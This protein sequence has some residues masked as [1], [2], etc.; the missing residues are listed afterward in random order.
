ML[1][2]PLKSLIAP[3]DTSTSPASKFVVSS[4]VVNVRYNFSSAVVE[5]DETVEL[6]AFLAVI[7]IVG[8]EASR[9]VM[10][11]RD[12]ARINGSIVHLE[13]QAVAAL[14]V[15]T[16]RVGQA[17]RCARQRTLSRLRRHRIAQRV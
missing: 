3:L 13:D 15:V 6:A 7:V 11:Y 4:L 10:L 17:G 9:T 1:D 16:R 12:S 5:L 2:T 14:E 8:A